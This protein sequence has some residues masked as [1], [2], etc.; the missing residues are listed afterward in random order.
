MKKIS[1][2]LAIAATSLMA[3]HD[4]GHSHGA[5][6]K[7]DHATEQPAAA[8]QDHD[9]EG[10]ST[11]VL[12]DNGKKW[13]ANPETID[14]VKKMSLMVRN[15]I[16]AKAAPDQLYEPL[17]K[18]FQTIFDKCTMKGEAHEQLHNFLIPVKANLDAIGKPGADPG[19]L[20]KL[21]KHLLTFSD[22]FE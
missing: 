11:T 4:A 15:G 9:H 5:D 21:E 1:Y 12:L 2:F 13:K 3:C 14:G 10:L 16:I 17:K 20:D 6:E 19:E 8:T 7:H 22:Y 18:E